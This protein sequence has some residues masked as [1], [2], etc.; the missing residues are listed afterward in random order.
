MRYL[1]VVMCLAILSG[2]GASPPH[3]QKRQNNTYWLTFPHDAVPDQFW[4]YPNKIIL[5][6]MEKQGLIPQECRK[7]VVI[8]EADRGQTSA[9]ACFE[10]I[11]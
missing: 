10:C 3:I 6:Y 5:G 7:G 8:I 9:Y 4:I 1:I 11:P 2:C